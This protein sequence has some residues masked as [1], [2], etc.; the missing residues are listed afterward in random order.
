MGQGDDLM[1]PNPRQTGRD[2]LYQSTSALLT[3]Y[4]TQIV[5]YYIDKA[6]LPKFLGSRNLNQPA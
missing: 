4:D 6:V 3:E 1:T 2:S 5:K